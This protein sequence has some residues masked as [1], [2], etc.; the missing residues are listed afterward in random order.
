MNRRR[1]PL[2]LRSAGRPFGRRARHRARSLAD[3]N[4][5]GG[6]RAISLRADLSD[7]K[8]TVMRGGEVIKEYDIAV[9]SPKYPT[10]RGLYMIEKIVWNPQWIPPDEVGRREEAAAAGRAARNPM[11][12]VK[13]FF[14]EPDYYIHG[15]GD[16]GSPWRS[17]IA[18][19]PADGS[20]RRRRTC[21]PADGQRGRVS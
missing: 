1:D 18:W 19:M 2:P 11:K 8:L 5:L 12:L 4:G 14:K 16:D 21:A 7:R 15:T 17:G 20:G 9:G 3:A 13:I 10:P 6:W